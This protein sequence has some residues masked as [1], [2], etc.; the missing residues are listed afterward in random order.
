MSATPLVAALIT[1]L[2]S[3]HCRSQSVQT[4]NRFETEKHLGPPEEAI[5][6]ITVVNRAP[7]GSVTTRHGNGIVIRCDGFV[8]APEALFATTVTAT[9]PDQ[10]VT[11]ILNPGTDHEQTAKAQR[12][13]A[14]GVL[15]VGDRWTRI[16]YTVFRAL[17]VHVPS[18]R[19]LAPAGL[20]VGDTVRILSSQWSE[21]QKRFLPVEA[22]ADSSGQRAGA[23]MDAA[24]ARFRIQ[25]TLFQK[26]LPKVA[27][28]AIVVGPEN[29]LVGMVTDSF[30]TAAAWYS[31]FDA[32]DQVTNCV[33]ALPTT[34]AKYEELIKKLPPV[35]VQ[36]TVVAA[37]PNAGANPADA[38]A[39]ADGHGDM[40]HIPGGPIKVPTVLKAYEADM[41]DVYDACMGPF[42]IDR[43]EV[44]N[45]QY[46][47]F[48]QSLSTAARKDSHT[49]ATL[50]PLGWGD[51]NAPFSPDLA[52]VP[53]LG[54][55]L[56]GAKAYAAWVGKRLPTPY[57]WCLAAF[58]RY[59]GNRP[60]EWADKYMRARQ[61]AWDNIVAA[62]IT[63]ARQHPEILP[64]FTI[65]PSITG[66]GNASVNWTRPF[67]EEFEQLP[68][69]F[70]RP[71]YVAAAAW[72]H[73]TVKQMTESLF[74]DWVDPGYILPV[75]SRA[76]DRSPYGVMDMTM[77][78]RELVLP[79]P[80]GLW[81]KLPND[82]WR[83]NDVDRYMEVDWVQGGLF[84]QPWHVD[85]GTI[86]DN[87]LPKSAEKMIG[88]DGLNGVINLDQFLKNS[89]FINTNLLISH[90]AHNEPGSYAMIL[91][92]GGAPVPDVSL[93]INSIDP[94]GLAEDDGKLLGLYHPVSSYAYRM[95]SRRLR[96]AS[97]NAGSSGDFVPADLGEYVTA[98]SAVQEYSEQL[99]PVNTCMLN[100]IAGPA[101]D[102]VYWGSTGTWGMANTF[103][104]N[105][106]TAGRRVG[107]TVVRGISIGDTGLNEWSSD[108]TCIALTG[109]YAD[110]ANGPDHY[111]QEMGRRTAI[112]ARY[113]LNVRNLN[114]L[115]ARYSPDTF[116]IP[117]GFRCAR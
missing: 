111:H 63:Y 53:V 34:D 105:N 29:M 69:F 61:L 75:G 65:Q 15:S 37:D 40:V 39:P 73:S 114:R 45:E 46:L 19:L 112:D 12:P 51:E 42:D 83:F 27:D 57:E 21:E 41:E 72:S 2:P 10:T 92:G 93:P 86:W 17:D 115:G 87:G 99:R 59:G 14:F 24:P 79:E 4:V 91:M 90:P 68:W 52:R 38:Q 22:I 13:R 108:A 30:D 94:P 85:S 64:G 106:P 8:L 44:T 43:Y 56:S 25:N 5:V 18:P 32:L 49:V 70:M 74:H 60:P 50:Y 89:T 16:G 113:N 66:A 62:H 103:Q 54:V 109:A 116:L 26:P 1:L 35:I 9:K 84:T 101:F 107:K 33:G 117:G 55:R 58:G 3:V 80:H 77:N 7:D 36:P 6:G 67:V 95:L 48:W 97:Q 71:G 20:A 81:K 47:A 82:H 96:S 98:C 78:A 31:N 23:G 28:G 11:V 88:I 100:L 102:V 110:W 104:I 76:Y